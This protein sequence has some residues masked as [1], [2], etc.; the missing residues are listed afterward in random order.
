MTHHL[1]IARPV[2]DLERTKAMYCSGLGLRLIGSFENH[3]GF[4][5]IMLG[6]PL[7]A[8]HFE[9][10]RCR[11]D[12]VAPTPTH[13]DLIVLYIAEPAEWTLRCTAMMTAGFTCVDSFNPYWDRDG[14]TF[15]DADG[16]RVVLQNAEWP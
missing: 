5:G 13:E 7:S 2:T 1:R 15:E 3:D 10:T 6:D 14:Q 4:D 9:F 12:P 16:Y 8:Y 11:E